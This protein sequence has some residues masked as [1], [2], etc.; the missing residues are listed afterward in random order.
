VKLRK[1]TYKILE[2]LPEAFGEHSLRP[3][4]V[5][6]WYSRYKSSQVSVEDGKRSGRPSTNKRTENVEKIQELIHED[7]RR[8]IDELAD[9]TGISYGVCQDDLNRKFQHALHYCKICPLT[10]DN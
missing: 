8:T 3:T 10:L 5:F 7:H 9:T 2:K 1:S 4:V 6:Y